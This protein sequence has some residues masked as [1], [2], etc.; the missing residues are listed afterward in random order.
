[1]AT[2]KVRQFWL[3]VATTAT[4]LLTASTASAAGPAPSRTPAGPPA[5]ATRHQDV[6][7]KILLYGDSLTMGTAAHYTWRYRLWKGLQAAG[8][9]VDFVGPLHT[10]FTYPGFKPTSTEYLD[11]NFDTA[12]AAVAGMTLSHPSFTVSA[13]AA[14][15]RPD[16]IVG[17]IGFNDLQDGIATPAQLTDI[18]R[19][20]IQLAR[21]A[22]PGVSVVLAEY[23]QT[24][25][26]DI[27]EYNA[28]L[29]ALALELDKPGARV[30]AS[31]APQLNIGADTF[32]GAHFTTSGEEIEA[33]VVAATLASLGL[34]SAAAPADP[35]IPSGMFA[36]AP[37]ATATPG[38]ITLTWPWVDYASSE[39]VMV[40]DVA[41]GQVSVRPFVQGTS[42]ALGGAPGHTYRIAL[43]PVQGWALIGTNSVPI[44][45]T[46]P[47]S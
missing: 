47:T 38:G 37:R 22:D 25:V 3:V 13:L 11:P 39:D 32:D 18:W 41:T 19:T 24:W 12:H 16:V 26:A 21:R 45:V 8:T 27:P 7:Q 44:T 35:P 29:T 2:G 33:S 40:Q 10:V 9:N 17:M 36:P 15:Y 4:V 6:P 5:A 30:I 14:A 42:L 34:P 20:Q 46:V 28:D 31:S 23:G 43:F 1:M